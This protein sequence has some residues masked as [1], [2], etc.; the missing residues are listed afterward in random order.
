MAG[1][2]TPSDPGMGYEDSK[3]ISQASSQTQRVDTLHSKE[4]T[5]ASELGTSQ[6]Q[7]VEALQSWERTLIDNLLN[8][9][10]TPKVNPNL[11]SLSR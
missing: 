6:T 4:T 2:P 8:F 3:G 1:T 7:R 5:D 11:H 10:S 9:A